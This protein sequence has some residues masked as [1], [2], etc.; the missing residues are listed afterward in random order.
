MK[1]TFSQ[2]KDITTGTEYIKE[3]N[4]VIEFHRFSKLEEEAYRDSWLSPRTLATAGVKFHFR[5]DATSLELKVVAESIGYNTLYAIDVFSNKR[6]VGQIKNYPDDTGKGD[7][8]K[9]EYPI[10]DAKGSFSL[11]DGEKEIEIYLPWSV[12]LGIKE[13]SLEGESFVSPVKKEK[14]CLIY[15]DSITQG[16]TALSPSNAYA[17]KIAD[18]LDAEGMNKAIGSEAYFPELVKA[19]S[20]NFNPDY[21]IV[22]YGVNDWVLRTY[23]EAEEKCRE[24]WKEAC[25]AY[26][27]AKKIALTPIWYEDK[28]INA[29]L[30]DFD[31]IEKFIRTVASEFSEITVIDCSDCVPEDSMFFDDGVHPTDEGFGYYFENLKK[32]LKDLK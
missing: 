9:N 3:N 30:G 1:L 18:W 16:A 11:D 6:L 27:G 10:G 2:I 14:R 31:K 22:S 25:A 23:E 21:L 15:G 12:K 17:V 4:G 32:K 28:N 19:R 8:T 26:R 29:K 7:R 13:I 24:F 20:G 5:T